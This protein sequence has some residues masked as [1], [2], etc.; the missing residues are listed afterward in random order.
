M[1]QNLLYLLLPFSGFFVQHNAYAQTLQAGDI[2][3]TGYTID[4]PNDFTFI[5]LLVEETISF[6]DEGWDGSHNTWY[7]NNGQTHFS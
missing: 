3:F 1:K 4:D 6:T 5:D 7:D 2:A